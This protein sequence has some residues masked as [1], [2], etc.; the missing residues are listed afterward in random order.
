MLP[1]LSP[2]RKYARCLK[3]SPRAAGRAG[4]TIQ[5][6]RSLLRK[7]R[8]PS[9]AVDLNRLV[10]DVAHVMHSDLLLHQVCLTTKLDAANAEI[11]GNRGELQQVLLNL[12]LNGTEAMHAI[13]IDERQLVITTNADSEAVELSVQDRGAG[14]PPGNFAPVAGAVLHHQIEGHRHGL[15][16]LR[17]YRARAPR[18]VVGGEQPGPR[19]D[20][21]LHFAARLRRTLHALGDG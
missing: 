9:A 13:P 7:E 8:E 15:V 2:L 21:A 4:D 20:L 10:Q 19:H 17:G 1:I 5:H 6:V 14:S 12:V 11:N 3:I 16:N 18:K